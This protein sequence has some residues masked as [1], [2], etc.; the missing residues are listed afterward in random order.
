[1]ALEKKKSYDADQ[2][3]TM[4]EDVRKQ[5]DSA[6]QENAALRTQLDSL[7][8]Q[9]TEIGDTLLSAKSLAKRVLDKA[10][11]Q[12]E[13]IVRDANAQAETI[14]R[15]AEAEA[16]AIRSGARR[17]AEQDAMQEQQEQAV[18]CVEACISQLKQQ[19][20][21]AIETLNAQWQE[22]LCGLTLSDTA[23]APTDTAP[24]DL[25]DKIGA[26]AREMQAIGGEE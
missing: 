19:H 21:D 13:E 17:E 9:R 7:N 15:E 4:L 16:E 2:V 25:S 12:A 6:R 10:R 26:I 11:R 23:E 14:L 20:L 22:F 8:S 5:A 24:D 3:K 18:R 1:M